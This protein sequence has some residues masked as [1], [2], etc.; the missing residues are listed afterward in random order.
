MITF[1]ICFGIYIAMTIGFCYW[2]ALIG[3]GYDF[4]GYQAPPL[5]LA[6]L[7]WPLALPF[8]LVNGL[9][10]HVSNVKDKRIER[11]KKQR[12]VRVAAEKEAEKLMQQVEEELEADVQVKN[13][14][15][16]G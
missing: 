4:D 3:L 10:N 1:L 14:I 6:A 5:V 7:F 2:D 11:E 15:R 16:Q 9:A 12:R 8:V 13:V